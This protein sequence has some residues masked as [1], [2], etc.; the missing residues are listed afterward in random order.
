MNDLTILHLSD[1]HIDAKGKKYSK[2]L[3]K[4]LSDI[5]ISFSDLS[6]KKIVVVVTGD[7]INQ[8]DIKAIPNAKA[9]FSDLKN[10]LMGKIAG[11]YLVP[12]NHDKYRTDATKFLISSFRSVMDNTVSYDM[13]SKSDSIHFDSSFAQNMWTFLED[14]YRQSGYFELINF[15]YDKLFP[16]MN[17]IKK[18]A[19]KTYGVHVLEIS[20]KK[21]CFVLLNTAWSCIDDKD[22]RHI[23]LGDFQL[24]DIYE[25]FCELADE[26]DLTFVLGHHPLESLYGSEQDRLFDRMI[27]FNGMSANAYICGHVHDRTIVNWSNNRHTIYTLMTG[28]GWPEYDGKHVHDHYYS[29]YNFNLGLN[30]MEILVKSSYD[31][32]EFKVDPRI[33]TGEYTPDKKIL[34][35]PIQFHENTGGITFHTGLDV[36]SKVL[37]ATDHFLQYCAEFARKLIEI[38]LESKLWL[39]EDK[40]DFLNNYNLPGSDL[41][42]DIINDIDR[43]IYNHMDNTNHVSYYEYE[44]D[45]TVKE[46]MSLNK[47]FI[48]DKFQG[49]LQKLCD[50]MEVVLVGKI[51]NDQVVRFHCRYLD[52]KSDVYRELCTSFSHVEDSEKY[53]LSDIEYGDL[54]EAIMKI[55]KD[56][57]GCL[58]YSINEKLCRHK[59]KD[60][61]RDF[62]TIIPH[63]QG[64]SCLRKGFNRERGESIPCLTF[65]VT[66]NSKEQDNILYCMDYF[67]IHKILGDILQTY[68]D[69]FLI[70][71]K[72]FCGW[73]KLDTDKEEISFD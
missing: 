28:I 18:I 47:I 9:F 46:I 22:Y 66:I 62:I 14:A 32:G 27:S 3:T 48:Y 60:R 4:L 73:V 30:S 13:L 39:E 31:N 2:L 15:I 23:I 42:E 33:Y 29:V 59:L 36:S 64:N 63:V 49:Y 7:V 24:E 56:Q 51:P 21:Y 71:I 38:S 5:E 58:I 57:T 65:G 20:E 61:W 40:E 35:R 37:Y 45:R 34:T 6:D 69:T 1:L 72:N 25:Q 19:R 26:V 55:S 17:V 12:G 67:S 43:L 8:G 53:T 41:K 10:A 50:K 52:Q 54:I 44:D 70:D 16:E 68:I 11:I